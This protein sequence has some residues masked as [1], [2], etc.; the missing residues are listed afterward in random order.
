MKLHIGGTVAQDGWK[1]LNIQPGPHVDY[2]GD[3]LD[4]SR[5]PDASASDIYLSHVLEHVNYHQEADAAVA[6]FKR[7]LA[8]G[9]K[10]MIA[11]PD[12]EILSHLLLAPFFTPQDKHRVMR[13]MFGGQ[14]DAHDYHRAGY[15]YIFLLALL[16]RGGFERIQRVQSF[17][18][19]NDTS[20]AAFNGV[21]IS[22]NVVA[23]RPAV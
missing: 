2:V 21:P 5:F 16:Q 10:L 22:L 20:N 6:G 7:V 8:P 23:Y 17:G 4:L 13:M 3:C 14:T 12:L 15:T 11:V 1:V 18:L 19:F 9:G